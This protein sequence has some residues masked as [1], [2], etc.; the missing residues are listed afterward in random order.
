MVRA[1]PP[2]IS[3]ALASPIQA[4]A[5]QLTCTDAFDRPSPAAISSANAGR[6]ALLRLDTGSYL[7]AYVNQP[8]QGADAQVYSQVVADLASAAQW[9][10]YGLRTAGA[11]GQAGVALAQM[12]GTIFLFYQRGS[13][14]HLCCQT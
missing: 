6:S 1:V 10:A 7:R 14:N 11:A 9:S 8:V 4:P 2:A 3:D 5:L 13:D 12:G